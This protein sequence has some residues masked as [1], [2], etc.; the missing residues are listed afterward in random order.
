MKPL[1]HIASDIFQYSDTLPLIGCFS[2]IIMLC[3]KKYLLLPN[4]KSICYIS[5]TEL[6][7]HTHGIALWSLRFYR[8]FTSRITR[9]KIHLPCLSQK[10][11][12]GV[13]SF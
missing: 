2:T 3:E 12:W 7:M 4:P 9:T 11:T 10:H 6:E 5:V 13:F 1:H 8:V